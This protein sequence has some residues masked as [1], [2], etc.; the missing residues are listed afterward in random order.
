LPIVPAANGGTEVAPPATSLS[1]A[2][3]VRKGA[4]Q[5]RL[6]PFLQ[7][8]V[9]EGRDLVIDENGRIV[10]RPAAPA[11]AGVLE[12]LLE[13]LHAACAAA[14]VHIGDI[15]PVGNAGA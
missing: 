6:T 14:G 2:A 12:R 1:P 13:P 3:P 15:G 10:L 9:R 7:Q 8:V 4:G 11:L 5:D